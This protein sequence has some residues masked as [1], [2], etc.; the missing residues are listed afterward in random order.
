MFTWTSSGLMQSVS[1]SASSA[2]AGSASLA[3]S[4]TTTETASSRPRVLVISSPR[5]PGRG[6]VV[7]D[8]EGLMEWD[9]RGHLGTDA[10]AADEAGPPAYGHPGNAPGRTR[11]PAPTT[12]AA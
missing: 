3:A 11:K 5:Q 4:A 10:R 12:G 9:Y 7:I 6:R 2:R 1:P 8:R